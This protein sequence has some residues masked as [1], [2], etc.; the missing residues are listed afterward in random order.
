MSGAGLLCTSASC[1]DLGKPGGYSL[2]TLMLET[3]IQYVFQLSFICLLPMFSVFISLNEA[4]I[5]CLV[6]RRRVGEPILPFTECLALHM[7]WLHRL[8]WPDREIFCSKLRRETLEK[9]ARFPGAEELQNAGTGY[10]S[11]GGAVL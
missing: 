5:G 8:G 2:G 11:A 9:T 1:A 7:M 10:A 3:T 4:Y 6:S